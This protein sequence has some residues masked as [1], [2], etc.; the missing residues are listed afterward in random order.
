MSGAGATRR[1][2]RASKLHSRRGRPLWLGPA[3]LLATFLVLLGL[4]LWI[5]QQRWNSVDP[6]ASWE[7]PVTMLIASVLAHVT[8]GRVRKA[9]TDAA[10]FQAAVVGYL[11]AGIVVALGVARITRVL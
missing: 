11:V 3:L 6:L 4:I 2:L 8:Q 9:P 10:K 7:H 1:Q 5:I